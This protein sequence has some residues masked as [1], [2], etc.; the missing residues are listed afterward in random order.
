MFPWEKK[1]EI[2]RKA[3]EFLKECCEHLGMNEKIFAKSAREWITRRRWEDFSEMKR[4]IYLAAIVSRKDVVEANHFPPRY[5]KDHEAYSATLFEEL[6]LEEIV[7]QKMSHFFER[8][9]NLNISGLHETVRTQVERALMT[10]S[11]RWAGGNQ[12]KAAKALGINRNTLRKK[13]REYGITNET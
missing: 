10:T 11:L 7:E 13:M 3:E 6:S 12:M 5:Q 8:V 4:I 9:R 2:L 1:R